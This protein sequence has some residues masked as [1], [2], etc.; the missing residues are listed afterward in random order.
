MFF[1]EV[2]TAISRSRRPLVAKAAKSVGRKQL[3]VLY[4]LFRDFRLQRHASTGSRGA[5]PQVHLSLRVRQ[6]SLFRRRGR[7]TH[8]TKPIALISSVFRLP[9]HC[10]RKDQSVFWSPYQSRTTGEDRLQNITRS[11][12]RKP[13]KLPRRLR[14][15]RMND[16]VPGK[17]SICYIAALTLHTN[18]ARLYCT[19]AAH[20]QCS[21]CKLCPARSGRMTVSCTFD[22]WLEWRKNDWKRPCRPACLWGGPD[23]VWAWA[24][25]SVNLWRS[26]KE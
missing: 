8:H 22:T 13:W 25:P 2:Q 1:P 7:D 6:Q 5:L 14:W 3:R 11:A 24:G 9:N 23:R 18:L 17:E 26:V 16:Q 4:A 21:T 19:I 12:E 10:K 20:H 15:C